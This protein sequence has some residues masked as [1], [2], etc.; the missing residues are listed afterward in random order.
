MFRFGEQVSLVKRLLSPLNHQ[1]LLTRQS[2]ERVLSRLTISRLYTTPVVEDRLRRGFLPLACR[3]TSAARSET[4]NKS[5]LWKESLQHN[6]ACCSGRNAL[7]ATTI[8]DFAK[9]GTASRRALRDA[10]RFCLRPRL[11]RVHHRRRLLADLLRR[12]LRS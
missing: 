12:G 8:N 4:A 11:T 3:F 9:L 6:L 2:S 1:L 10:P 7:R 5:V